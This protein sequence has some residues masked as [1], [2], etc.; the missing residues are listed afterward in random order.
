MSMPIEHPVPTEDETRRKA[1]GI[2]FEADD[3]QMQNVIE[4]QKTAA[5]LDSVISDLEEDHLVGTPEY[6]EAR[7]KRDLAANGQP[8]ATSQIAAVRVAAATR[9]DRVESQESRPSPPVEHLDPS[10]EETPTQHR[11]L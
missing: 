10:L 2:H 11:T 9:E 6:A 5:A 7:R 1:G 3:P 4:Q 8:V